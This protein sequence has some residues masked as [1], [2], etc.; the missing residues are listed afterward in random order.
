MFFFVEESFFEVGEGVER[1]VGNFVEAE[2]V[3]EDLTG[4]MFETTFAV[5]AGDLGGEIGQDWV[6]VF[7]AIVA[8]DFFDE[9]FG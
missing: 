2:G 8:S 6:E 7:V 3:A 4:A 5:V 9:I 1:V